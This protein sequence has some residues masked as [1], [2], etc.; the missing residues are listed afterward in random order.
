MRRLAESHP[1]NRRSSK[2]ACPAKNRYGAPSVEIQAIDIIIPH[3]MFDKVEVGLPIR[4]VPTNRAVV[5]AYVHVI[6]TGAAA[7][8]R[9]LRVLRVIA[10]DHGPRRACGR[11]EM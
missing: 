9:A 5:F 1:G 3:H 11:S 2:P 7:G 6:A 10:R 8:P 4:R